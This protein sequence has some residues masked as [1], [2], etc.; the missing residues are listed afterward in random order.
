MD[1]RVPVG[2]GDPVGDADQPAGPVVDAVQRRLGPSVGVLG[3]RHHD[4][5]VAGLEQVLDLVERV[6][7]TRSPLWFASIAD[8]PATGRERARH[9][10]APGSNVRRS[11]THRPHDL[12][13]RAPPLPKRAARVAPRNHGSHRAPIESEKAPEGLLVVAGA[14]FEPATSG[15]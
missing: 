13:T 10:L 2:T 3:A 15:L 14:G 9:T 4:L 6:V 8:E 12:R 1:N 7:H 11:D 5:G